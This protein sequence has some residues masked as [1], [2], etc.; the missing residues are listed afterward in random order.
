MGLKDA[1][2]KCQSLLDEAYAYCVSKW[3]KK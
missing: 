2:T 1:A 3:Y